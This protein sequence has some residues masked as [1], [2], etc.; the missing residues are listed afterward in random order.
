[1]EGLFIESE[2]KTEQDKREAAEHHKE[3]IAR[4]RA[5]KETVM[6]ERSIGARKRRAEYMKQYRERNIVGKSGESSNSSEE[7]MKIDD[8]P[9]ILASLAGNA[10]A[11]TDQV[12]PSAKK[13]SRRPAHWKD[14]ARH[15]QQAR[16]C[17]SLIPATLWLLK[18]GGDRSHLRRLVH[19]HTNFVFGALHTS[20]MGIDFI[21]SVNL[22][23]NTIRLS[24]KG[25]LIV[26]QIV[27]F[28][29]FVCYFQIVH[30]N[31]AVPIFER[32]QI[33]I[34]TIAADAA[35]RH[36]ITGT[37]F[38]PVHLSIRCVLESLLL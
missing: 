37:V 30:V 3:R 27:L 17:I 34:Y 10:T 36:I 20:N 29:T 5:V 35:L 38:N 9:G 22:Q 2:E 25:M 23:A 11:V 4:I 33:V 13:W 1:M 24:N 21:D 7:D 6:K 15:F 28:F 14:A 19:T 8:M 18:S 12:L 31:W 16:R 26:C 32:T